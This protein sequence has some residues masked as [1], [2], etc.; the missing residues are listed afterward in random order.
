M[1]LSNRIASLAARIG[2]EVKSK[3]DGSHPGLARAWV[4]FGY[5]NG[6]MVMHST[7]N[8]M[9]VE[10][11]A[12]GRYRV[13]FTQPMPD[14]TYAWIALARSST[15]NGTQRIAIARATADQ[16]TT[17]YVDVAC[18]TMA[19]SFADSTEINLVVYR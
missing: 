9:S 17:G 19:S 14:T 8:V 13:H 1:S 18:A 15:D 12:T 4:S 11:L 7:R 10:R 3:I 5:V 6:Q 16:K 2:I